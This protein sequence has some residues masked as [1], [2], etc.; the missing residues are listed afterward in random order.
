MTEPQPATET[1]G[2]DSQVSDV[3]EQ[4]QP[5]KLYGPRFQRNPAEVY[6]EMRQ[7]FGSVAPVLVEGDVPA[8]LVL[9][10]RELHQAANTPRLFSRDP[11]Y[12]H[13]ID[14]VSPEWSLFPWVHY[15]PS[16]A[17]TEG[18]EHQ[19]LSE[20]LI[21]ALN[22]VDQFD[23]QAQCER[24][25]DRLID[26]F[27]GRGEA[28]LIA[29]YANRMPIEALAYLLGVPDSETPGLTRDLIVSMDGGEGAIEAYQ[30][31]VATTRRLAE[32]KRSQPGPDVLS[33]LLAHKAQFTVDEADAAAQVLL[34]A[35]HQNTSDWLGNTLRLMLSDARFAV[36]LS[37]G[38]RSIGQAL[39]EVLWEDTPLQNI[40]GRWAVRDTQLGGQ[41]IRA[42]DMLILG[43]AAANADPQV[44]P[45]AH[46]DSAG[47]QAHLSFGHGE[48][49]C[50]F[51]AA[52][53]AEII[54]KIAV[55]VLLDRLPDVALAVHPDALVWRQ[56][57]W[58][59]GLSVLP[60]EFTAGHVSG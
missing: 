1:S 5:M 9:G 46:A 22:A 6:R 55:E 18:E 41:R 47:N 39:N 26:G 60:V 43:F 44:R 8:W 54:V 27:I 31:A 40:L 57:A 10:Y 48:H 12:W 49:R 45:D 34:V 59:R 38:R 32:S 28:D 21:D 7:N 14:S 33:R 37:G 11:R 19:R 53:H 42:G 2:E 36:S 58:I 4:P 23:F 50:P 56:S 24:I 52:E 29:S 51:P 15:T 13:S 30:R 25:A 3:T 16:V 20:A 17:F 35:G